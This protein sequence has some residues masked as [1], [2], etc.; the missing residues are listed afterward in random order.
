MG[1]RAFGM[2][3][4]IDATGEAQRSQSLIGVELDLVRKDDYQSWMGECM[5]C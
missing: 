4:F 3:V 1:S 5:A 2:N